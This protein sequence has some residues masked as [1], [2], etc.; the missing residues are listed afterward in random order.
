MPNEEVLQL[1]DGATT[2]EARNLEDLAK[3][4]RQRYPDEAYE[5]TLHRARD[6]QAEERRA[7]ALRRL[8]EILAKTAV[9]E[10]F[11]ETRP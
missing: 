1:G 7:D 5:R 8:I 6:Y 11:Q 2:L 10:H 4:L 3:Q 9:K